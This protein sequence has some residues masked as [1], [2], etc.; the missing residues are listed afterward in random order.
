[1]LS[2]VKTSL[3][4]VNNSR[5]KLSNFKFISNTTF[6]YN[7]GL[8]LGLIFNCS[9]LSPNTNLQTWINYLSSGGKHLAISH[10]RRSTRSVNFR[11]TV[12]NGYTYVKIMPFYRFSNLFLCR[13]RPFDDDLYIG[14]SLYPAIPPHFY[15]GFVYIFGKELKRGGDGHGGVRSLTFPNHLLSNTFSTYHTQFSL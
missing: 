2:K 13:F 12:V 7:R 1:M 6:G 10:L 9:Y 15:V 11:F 8:G 5:L 4:K 3:T 14:V